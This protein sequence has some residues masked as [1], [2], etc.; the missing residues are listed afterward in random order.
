MQER[1]DSSHIV[2][3]LEVVIG[4]LLNCQQQQINNLAR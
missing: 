1:R 2:R 4:G 3:Q